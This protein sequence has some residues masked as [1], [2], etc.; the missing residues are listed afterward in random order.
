MSIQ[1]NFVHLHYETIKGN[2]MAELTL[3]GTRGLEMTREEVIDLGFK[4]DALVRKAQCREVNQD[5]LDLIQDVVEK[6]TEADNLITNILEGNYE[7]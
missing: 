5:V 7:G 4:A 3:N 6:L 2:N 1:G